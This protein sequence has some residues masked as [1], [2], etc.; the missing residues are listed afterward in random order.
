MNDTQLLRTFEQARSANPYTLA[1][2]WSDSAGTSP[3]DRDGQLD[4]VA[5]MAALSW[6]M[7]H[8]LPISVHRAL[9]AGAS[10]EEV[11]EASGM[12]FAQV[13][14]AWRTW[15]D[16]QRSLQ[17]EHANLPDHTGEYDLIDDLIRSAAHDRTLPN[18][19]GNL[20]VRSGAGAPD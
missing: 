19:A 5:T 13:T 7:T 8:W 20:R 3:T 17:S 12:Q 10:I 2:R 6:W 1:R 15:A 14:N 11:A 9:M 18:P 16:G 4:E